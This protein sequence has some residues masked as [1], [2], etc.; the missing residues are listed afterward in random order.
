MKRSLAFLFEDVRLALRSLRRAPGFAAVVVIPLALGIGATTSIFSVVHALLLEPLPFPD[1]E[2]LVR[3]EAVR[4][5][6][7]ASLSYREIR[8]FQELTGVFQDVAA[9]TDQ[10]QYNASGHGRPEELVSTITTQNLFGVLGTPL[11][12]GA[13]WPEVLDR[14]RDFKLVISHDLWQR[15]FG[16]DPDVVG[17]TLTLDGAP[18]YEILG[19]LPRGFAFP[20]RSDLYR[21]NGIAADAAAYENRSDRGRWGVGRLREGVTLARAEAALTDL[22]ERL[23]RDFP[24]SNTGVRYRM[25]PLR[26]MYAGDARPYLLLVFGAVALVLLIAC[27]NVANL[28]LS[29]ALGREREVGVRLA[30]GAPRGSVLRLLLVESMTLAAVGGALGVLLAWLSLGL[31]TSLIRLD[32]PI[33]LSIDLSWEVLLGGVVASLLVGMLT[34]ALPAWRTGR[35]D[36]ASPLKEGARGASSGVRQRNLRSALVV[37]EVAFA[38]MLLVGAGLLVRSFRALA[39]TSPGFDVESLLTFRVELGWRAYPDLATTTAFGRALLEDLRA[40]PGVEVAAFVSNLP[41]GGR[42]K[43]DVSVLVDGQA[44]AEQRANPFLNLR[45]ASADAFRALR[46]PLLGGRVFGDEDRA[47]GVP[48]AVISSATAERLWPGQDP[49]GMRM[50]VGAVDDAAPWRT[51]V[52]VVGDVRHEAF[53]APASLDVYLPAEQSATGG[54]YFLLRTRGDPL[55]LARAAPELVWDVDP[56]QSFFD[57]RTMRER[58]EDRIWVPRLA[59]L[60]SGGFAALAALLAA[61]GVYAVL[62]YSVAQRTRELGLR[63]ALGASRGHLSRQIVFE[64]LRLTA[65]GGAIGLLAA[66]ALASAIRPLL[67]GVS[68]IDPPTLSVAAGALLLLAVSAAWLPARRAMRVAPLEALRAEG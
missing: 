3:L 42:P 8:D 37:S 7:P 57:V 54:H 13:P 52:G 2:R 36:L 53:G 26:E 22:A 44:A 9:Y 29:R 23:E 6:E 34:G 31:L 67:Y 10:G 1:A 62:A 45:V 38:V 4:G 47:D 35:A 28:L 27:A 55:A 19:V 48:V 17:R 59:S 51:V 40:L 12:L 41:L 14:T 18:G 63:Q 46:I 56:D 25:T 58:V 16:G 24:D 64:C 39:S 50:K 49:V 15:R 60:L 66:L 32:L 68:V 5:G 20:I 21:S 43:V 61:I 65:A 30:L 11:L 33:W